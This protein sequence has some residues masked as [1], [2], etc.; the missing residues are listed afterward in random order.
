[1][2]STQ[3]CAQTFNAN[4][5]IYDD[6]RPGYPEPLYQDI[7]A[8]ADMTAAATILEIGAG[9]G[10]ATYEM[11]ARWNVRITALEP[12]AELL[13]LARKRCRQYPN[14]RFVQSTFE[15]Y[16]TPETFDLIVAATAYHWIDPAVKLTKPAKLLKDSGVLAVF[17]N[18]YTRGDSPVFDEIDA[19]YIQFHPTLSD[20]RDGRC[21]IREKIQSRI[22]ELQSSPVLR[23]VHHR[24]YTF[25][26]RLAT[27]SYLK[28]L[29]T[30]SPNA[31]CP[32][33]DI[34]PFYQEIERI[35]A[36]HGDTIMQPILVNLEILQK[37]A[38]T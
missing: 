38:S 13:H 15:E 9:S 11:A 26:I 35:L 6:V 16:E 10:I 36:H 28:L 25:A 30:F 27:D 5:A 29:K 3:Q 12:G 21:I 31:V 19:A 4:A 24:E 20:D 2:N 32:P 37:V 33:D 18:N 22:D 34:A 8:L 1:M 7:Q 17:W 14:I 23:H